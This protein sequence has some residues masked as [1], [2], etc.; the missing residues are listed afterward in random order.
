[1]VEICKIKNNLNPS[2]MNFFFEGRNNTYSL[3]NSQDFATE[4]KIIAKMGL[5]YLNCRSPQL[6]SVLPENLG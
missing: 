1:M 2:I 5:E 3:I 6:W 4:R